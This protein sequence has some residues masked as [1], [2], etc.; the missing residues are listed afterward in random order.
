MA[1]FRG[2]RSVRSLTLLLLACVLTPVGASGAAAGG[3]RVKITGAR[4]EHWNAQ[5]LRV[6]LRFALQGPVA[7]APIHIEL[8]VRDRTRELG[9]SRWALLVDATSDRR[10]TRGQD[11]A[12]TLRVPSAD[13]WLWV[14]VAAHGRG[15]AH[16][17]AT[18]RV[19]S[20]HR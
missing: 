11:A 7:S 1:P 15:G 13:R 8:T 5:Q 10:V 16:A 4:A 19:A 6:Y 20:P 17:A 3:S 2:S 12:V 9:Q 14:H 18:V